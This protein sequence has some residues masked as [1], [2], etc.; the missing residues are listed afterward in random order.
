MDGQK[1]FMITPGFTGGMAST[2]VSHF[3]NIQYPYNISVNVKVKAF[4][5]NPYV[6]FQ[7]QNI[8]KWIN[9]TLTSDIKSFSENATSFGLYASEKPGEGVLLEYS[10]NDY[11]HP[12]PIYVNINAANPTFVM[13]LDDMKVNDAYTV[14]SSGGKLAIQVTSTIDKNA[15]SK[16]RLF[17]STSTLTNYTTDLNAISTSSSLNGY[18]PGNF[19]S[20]SGCFTLFREPGNNTYATALFSIPSIQNQNCISEGN[21]LQTKNH[22]LSSDDINLFQVGAS[23]SGPCEMIILTSQNSLPLISIENVSVTADTYFV[24]KNLINQKQ[25]FNLSSNDATSFKKVGIYSNALSIMIQAGTIMN[26]LAY[27]SNGTPF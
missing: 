20:K 27:N 16:Y 9:T 15:L 7:S 23:H 4:R 3:Y 21:V 5:G 1:G 25:L 22:S 10:F 19:K 2:D 12:N 17:D 26:M 14:C 6:V 8:D 24:F 13:W 11:F 18:V